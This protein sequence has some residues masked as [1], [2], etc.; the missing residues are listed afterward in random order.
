M[1][2]LF[3]RKAL[4]KRIKKNPSEK[5]CINIYWDKQMHPYF[6]FGVFIFISFLQQPYDHDSIGGVH[7]ALSLFYVD[8][9]SL[10]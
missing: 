4:I 7:A 9:Y 6:P 2:E 3:Y 8:G 10:V 1:Q 5:E